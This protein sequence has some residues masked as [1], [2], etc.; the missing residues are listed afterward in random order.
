MNL[1][2]LNCEKFKQ[3]EFKQYFMSKY[4]VLI[5]LFL[6]LCLQNK[7]ALG[8]NTWDNIDSLLINGKLNPKVQKYYN[9]IYKAEQF[10]IE[11]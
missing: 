6:C 8:Q 9:N 11:E 3:I 4:I 5:F 7:F 1:E 2:S 10:I